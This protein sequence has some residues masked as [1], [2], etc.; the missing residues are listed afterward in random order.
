MHKFAK[1][2][3]FLA[4]GSEIT[5]GEIINTNTQEM[6]T[7][8]QDFGIHTGEH[9]I[10]DD[11]YQ[12]IEASLKFLL[13][14][15]EAVIISGG[16]G[17]TS[18]DC[19]KDVVAKLAE[20]PL[21]FHETSW[22][23]I[24]AR[25]SKRNLPIPE[26]NRQ[27]A[28]FPESA[29]VIVNANGTADACY[30]TIGNTLVFLLPGPP[31]EC[32]PIFEAEV[33]GLLL[34]KGYPT[35]KRLFRWRLMGVSES[36]IAELLQPYVEEHGLEFAYRATYPFVD[37]KLF[38]APNNKSHKKI[39]F[40]I[41]ALVQPYFV[42]HLNELMQDQLKYH[43]QQ[44]PM[45]IYIHDE[46]TF[47]ALQ[48]AL[49]S[50]ETR[51]CFVDKNNKA[52]LEIYIRGLNDYWKMSDRALTDVQLELKAGNK[53]ANFSSSTLLRGPETLQYVIEFAAWKIL[54]FI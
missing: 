29:E 18:D 23:K 26:N 46:A 4:T 12:N 49:M 13:A 5:T 19:T 32:L 41:Q 51:H 20:K 31:R 6:A 10:A 21:V 52:D 53:D 7:Q 17:P 47:G 35:A 48:Q 39:I 43:L 1:R 33:L 28:Y 24:V 3:G 9:L 54:N 42:T 44:H 15:H 36:K 16:L 38:V 2:V 30:L 40:E 8:L 27:Q 11:H 14:R 50:P 34:K 22:E 25:L 37:I 45:S